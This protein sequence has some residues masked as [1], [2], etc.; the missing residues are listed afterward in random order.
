ML[1][2]SKCIRVASWD[3]DILSLHLIYKVYDTDNIIYQSCE[4]DRL[5]ADCCLSLGIKS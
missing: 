3:C 5:V 4:L 2:T 1:V